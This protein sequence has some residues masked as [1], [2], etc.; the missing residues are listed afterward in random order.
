MIL[1]TG[2]PVEDKHLMFSS[3]GPTMTR[4]R[5][6]VFQSSV[7]EVELYGVLSHMMRG[8]EHSLITGLSAQV[9]RD[10]C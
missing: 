2:I 9:T 8:G 1:L 10:A 4:C 5:L 3:L 7:M 6:N